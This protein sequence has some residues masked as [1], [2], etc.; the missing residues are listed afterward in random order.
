VLRNAARLHWRASRRRQERERHAPVASDP[1]LP[2]TGLARLE[3]QRLLVEIVIDL[4]DPYR[5]TLILRFVDGLSAAEIARRLDVPAATV[6]SRLK[7]SLEM[8]RAELDRR[9][10]GERNRWKAALAP[11]FIPANAP[12]AVASPIALGGLAMKVAFAAVITASLVL[13]VASTRDS[14][15]GADAASSAQRSSPEPSA[16]PG[17]APRPGIAAKPGQGSARR[18]QSAAERQQFA[19]ALARARMNAGERSIR[20]YDYSGERISK[21]H[22]REPPAVPTSTLD[23]NYIRER[24]AEIRPLL[25]E[26]YELAVESENGLAGELVVEFVVDAEQDIGGY[27]REASIADDSPLQNPMLSEC[28]TETVLSVVFVPP[29]GGGE[30]RVRYPLLFEQGHDDQ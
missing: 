28:V 5:E 11:L 1:E 26:C 16:T 21:Q 8:V 22:D 6:R 13:I 15:P 10:D 12:A 19:T 9:N 23:K 3:L 17:P 24:I 4:G 25:R 27:V 2:D 18:F 20:T 30:V 29:E 7:R 14:S